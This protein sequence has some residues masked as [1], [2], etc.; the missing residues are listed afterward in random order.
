[1]NLSANTS[2]VEIGGYSVVTEHYN[3]AYVP[4]V[5]RA[6]PGDVVAAH[7]EN[8]LAPRNRLDGHEGHGDA[9]ENPTNLHYFHGGIVTPNN[10]RPPVDASQGNG[11]NIYVHLKAG[12]DVEGKPNS[13]DFKVPIPGEGELD[14][15][16]LEGEGYISHPPGLNWYHSHLHGIS[17]TQVMGGLSGLLSVGNDDANLRACKVDPSDK[18]KCLSEADNDT[19]EVEE[20]TEKLREKTD[21]KYVLLRDIPLRA[22]G[23]HPEK[24]NGA[25]AVWAPQ[26]R[27]LLGNTPCGVWRED[28]SRLDD[29]KQFRRGFCQR[30]ENSAWLF[31]LNGQRFPTI[32][33]EGGRNVLLRIGNLSANVAYWLELYDEHNESDIL[34]LTILGLDGVVPAKP[35]DPGQAKIPIEAFDVPDLL[36]MPA[37]RAEV[38]VRNDFSH[39]DQRVY[40][41]RTKHL[42]M[43]TDQWP[44]IQLARVVLKP[45][46]VP[47]KIALALN[48]SIEQIPAALLPEA[49]PTPAAPPPMPEGCFRDIDPAKGEH[50][51]MSFMG[52]IGGRWKVMTEIVHPPDV[53]PGRKF[54]E[55]EF[56]PSEDGDSSDKTTIPPI[57]FE[58]YEQPDGIDWEGKHNKHVCIRLDHHGS[59]QQLWVLYNTTSAVHNFHIHQMKFRLATQKELEDHHIL[60]PTSAQTCDSEQCDQPNYKFYEKG[61]ATNVAG[62]RVRWHDT[63]PI[64]SGTKVFLIMS[65]DA[66]EQVGRFVFHCHI[67]KHEDNGLMAP[68]EVWDPSA[69][70]D[71]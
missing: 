69:T 65:F 21:V 67:L 20:Q 38:Y 58:V 3:D 13:F 15:R 44:E 6:Q 9:G 4:P 11:D 41:L 42:D 36:L 29:N 57:P 63:I 39:G 18:T 60:P 71:R 22:I 64:P 55:D 46:E 23:A 33:V 16:V 66:P 53:E 14:A 32:T 68:I 62:S 28:E 54:D 8:L 30:D 47:S 49:A 70:V 51:R 59:H 43:G 2:R 35:V 1:V 37:S 12:R 40:V 34:R 19:P 17:S 5:V 7:L 50:R 31:T 48:A 24:A 56:L 61:S 52:P 45:N 25:G 27:D 26:D 10:A